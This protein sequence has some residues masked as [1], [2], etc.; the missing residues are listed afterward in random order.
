M[1]AR[2]ARTAMAASGSASA[3]DAHWANP[4]NWNGS[5]YFC[6][7]D[8]RVLV[9]KQ[10]SMVSYGWT[11]N[12]GNPTTETCLI[13]GIVAVPVVILAAERG[14]FG[15]AFNAAAKWLRR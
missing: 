13:V 15:K 10:P 7:A 2:P 1:P 3:N 4:D 5:L 9:P 6:K 11:L 8:T 14:L 12:L